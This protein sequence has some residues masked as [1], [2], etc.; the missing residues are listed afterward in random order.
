MN[1]THEPEI[2]NWPAT[3]YVFV[4][5]VGPFQQTAGQA[6]QTAHTF[7]PDLSKNNQITR[8]MS[9]YKMGPQVYRAGFALSAPPVDLPEGLAYE[10]F[11]GGTYSQFMLTGPYTDLPAASGKAWNLVAEKNIPLREDFAIENY[12]NDPRTTPADQ[13]VTQI[14]LPTA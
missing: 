1:L 3:H 5:K 12:A 10:E 13:L 6:W 9:L 2:I 11:H 8:Y 7:V 4:E 14:L